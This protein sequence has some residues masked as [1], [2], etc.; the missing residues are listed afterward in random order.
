MPEL[1][2][3]CRHRQGCMNRYFRLCIP[4][5]RSMGWGG[6]SSRCRCAHLAHRPAAD[7]SQA[8]DGERRPCAHGRAAQGV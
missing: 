2:R 5:A 1:C 6:V 4:T 8:R 7:G 3:A